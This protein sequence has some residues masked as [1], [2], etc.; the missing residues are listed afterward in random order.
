MLAFWLGLNSLFEFAVAIAFIL[1]PQQFFGAEISSLEF[2]LARV[3]GAGA[4]AIGSLSLFFVLNQILLKSSL[5]L[6]PAI[7]TL[8][9]FHGSVALVQWLNFSNQAA[10]LAIA[11]IHSGFA[12]TFLVCSYRLY[13][14]S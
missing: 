8:A 12:V 4:I 1:A 10:P 7:A 2:A 13:F 14:P 6:H 5:A 9:I 11:I 3:V